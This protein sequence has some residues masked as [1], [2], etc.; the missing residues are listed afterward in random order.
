MYNPQRTQRVKKGEVVTMTVHILD[1]SYSKRVK[2]Q[3]WV[4]FNRYNGDV[5]SSRKRAMKMLSEMAK[6]VSADP[7]CY[8]V[9]FN[10]N[11]RNLRYRWKNW[12]DDEIERFVQIESKEVK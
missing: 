3:S 12:G 8:D 11:R 5:Y 9:V 2:G 1:N 10:A 6:S 4:M 7:E